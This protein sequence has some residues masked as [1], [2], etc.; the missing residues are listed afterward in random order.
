MDLFR[1]F[2]RS[3]FSDENLEFWI[4]CEDYKSAKGGQLGARAHQI[5]SDFVAIQAP[6]EVNLLSVMMIS[7]LNKHSNFNYRLH[8]IEYLFVQCAVVV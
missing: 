8:N 7:T 5:Y 6:H 2:L 3:E 4:A 1:D